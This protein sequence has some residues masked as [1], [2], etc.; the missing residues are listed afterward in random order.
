MILWGKNP[1]VTDIHMLPFIHEARN[2]GAKVVLIDPV[3]SESAVLVKWRT[4]RTKPA[5]EDLYLE[6]A[7][8]WCFQCAACQKRAGP[9]PGK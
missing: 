6:S 5:S 2:L 3:S 7:G 8:R 1:A 9:E 4:F